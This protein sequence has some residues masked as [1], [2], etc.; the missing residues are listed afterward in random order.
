MIKN[1]PARVGD[2][3]SIP[4]SG[5]SPE[6]ENDNP[7]QYCAWEIPWAEEPSRLQ[8]KLSQKSQT[9]FKDQTTATNIYVTGISQFVPSCSIRFSPPVT[10]RHF[11]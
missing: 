6:E 4:G 5:R 8:S 2:M 7:L 1:L 3:G 10:C 11:Q 9:Q